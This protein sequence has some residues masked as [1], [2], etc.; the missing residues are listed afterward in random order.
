MY[1]K[2][3][4]KK[5]TILNN[6]MDS[7]LPLYTLIASNSSHNSEHRAPLISY[8]LLYKTESENSTTVQAIYSLNV[9]RGNLR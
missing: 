6:V 2:N 4:K 5:K 7:T 3:G 1:I 8:N 9:N